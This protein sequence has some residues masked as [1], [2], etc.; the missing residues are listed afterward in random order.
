MP[1]NIPEGVGKATEM[2]IKRRVGSKRLRK[3][4]LSSLVTFTILPFIFIL[5]LSVWLIDNFLENNLKESLNGYLNFALTQ[6]KNDAKS[7]SSQLS[8]LESFLINL[9]DSSLIDSALA[10]F[11]KKNPE[12]NFVLITDSNG[13]VINK[14]PYSSINDTFLSKKLILSVSQSNKTKYFLELLSDTL[15]S[16][17]DTQLADNLT[18]KDSQGY[19]IYKDALFLLVIKPFN[20]LKNKFFIAGKSFNNNEWISTDFEKNFGTTLGFASRNFVVTDS[21]LSDSEQYKLSLKG[22]K[23]P[24]PV[25]PSSD[26]P[27]H[28]REIISNKKIFIVAKPVYGSLN[29]SIGY[30]FAIAG[31]RRINQILQA[32]LN[33]NIIVLSVL[34]ISLIFTLVGGN[35]ISNKL[36][37][38]LQKLASVALKVEEGN[39]SVRANLNTG[40]EI[41]IVGDRMDS[42]L[43]RIVG[44]IE[45][46]ADRDKLQNQITDLLG[47][48]SNAA[49]GNL[50]VKA[51]VFS[52]T[53][54]ALADSFNYMI[55]EIANLINRVKKSSQQVGKA[56]EEIT[57]ITNQMTR[58]SEDQVK[59]IERLLISINKM[60]DSSKKVVEYADIVANTAQKASQ[61]AHIGG[62]SVELAIQGMMNLSSV[63]QNTSQKIIALEERSFEIGKIVRVIEEIAN[64]TNLLAL[65]ATIEAA[66]A[67]DAG[68]GFS[69]VADE[70]RKLA[71]RVSKAANDIALIIKSIQQDTS[72]VVSSME[73]SV[74]SANE[75]VK[76]SDKAAKSLE[77]IISVV[78]QTAKSVQEITSISK[79][80]SRLIQNAND[81]A[82]EIS[83]VSRDML[84]GI[85]NTAQAVSELRNLSKRLDESISKFILP[86]LES[87]DSS[88]PESEA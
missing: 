88:K 21:K 26:K 51:S 2:R 7:I 20:S 6:I 9:N 10:L 25:I 47:T 50:T 4:L 59:E 37:N 60:T 54:G 67:G 56:T 62:E 44:L 45:T 79:D 29:Q 31:P 80:Q 36:L 83:N 1:Q 66:R 85:I 55:E 57:N 48:V 82:T 76:L 52:G 49:E 81:A 33:T 42:M 58:R 64:Q 18:I 53:L 70:V 71:E 35:I 24:V 68:K 69:V 41:Q 77:E 22:V 16:L 40:D 15:I 39:Y 65:N 19:I 87:V 34:I 23:L 43:D 78:E 17:L 63:V 3:R 73:D 28:L 14:P 11:L 61:V 72:E 13:F 32:N 75:G 38:P 8:Q 5:A 84:Q 12:I 46:E 86:S 27:V 74:K 30:I